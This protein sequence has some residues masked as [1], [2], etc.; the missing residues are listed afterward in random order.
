VNQAQENRNAGIGDRTVRRDHGCNAKMLEPGSS[1]RWAWRITVNHVMIMFGRETV[2]SLCK[3][4]LQMHNRGVRIPIH[5]MCLLCWNKKIIQRL[6]F[7][8]EKTFSAGDLEMPKARLTSGY[9]A[10][11][12]RFCTD[13]ER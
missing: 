8:K 3:N 2:S 9:S 13:C 5:I 1:H 4:L 11:I 6:V 10:Y 7:F 12:E